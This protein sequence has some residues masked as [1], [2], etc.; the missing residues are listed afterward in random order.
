MR[1]VL[2]AFR[3]ERKIGPAKQLG[4]YGLLELAAPGG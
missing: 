3:G 4:A 1:Q 2:A